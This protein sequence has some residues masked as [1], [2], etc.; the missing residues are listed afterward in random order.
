[1]KTPARSWSLLILA[2]LG[3]GG[4]DTDDVS[5]Q[6]GLPRAE[7]DRISR[8]VVRIVSLAGGEPIQSGSGT[9]V[10]SSGRIYT[11]RHVVEGGEDFLIE[12][13]EDPNEPPTP[14][15][16]ARLIGYSPDIDFAQLQIDRDLNGLAKDPATLDLPFLSRA[17]RDPARGDR[18]FVFGYPAIGDGYQVLT[19]G[20]LT[21]IRNG[22]LNDERLP[23]WYQTDAQISPGNSGGLAVNDRGE[24]LGIPT[25]V[26]SEERTLGRLGGILA[27]NAV[28][29][30][31]DG[32]LASDVAGMA[33]GTTSPVIENGRLD[34]GQEP[35]FGNATLA[36]GFSPDP[37]TVTLASG[38]E[39][40]VGYLGGG[41]TGHAAVAPDYRINWTGSGGALRV[42]FVGEDG[43]D[44][45]LLINRP[46]GSWVCNDDWS[47]GTVDPGIVLENAPSGQYDIWVGSYAAG[48][49]VGG[50]L[51]VTELE[52]EPTSVAS[53]GLDVS[54]DPYFGT[55]A[56]RA[57][58]DESV[59]ATEITAGGSVDVGYLGGGCIGFAGTAPDLRLNWTGGGPSL[60]IGFEAEDGGDATLIVNLP[61]GTWRCIDDDPAG[62]VDPFLS[63]PRPANGQY[64][65][66]VGTYQR[67]SFIPGILVLLEGDGGR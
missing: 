37:H 18:I 31:V 9:V 40:S 67:G 60:D 6:S 56:L 28:Q 61:D 24:F 8:S 43:G 53:S 22:T 20:T 35:F 19:E 33:S 38:G 39:V 23:V 55:I 48:A 54:G 11:N 41:C 32:G 14:R 26:R 27:Y 36:A 1:M 59:Y 45:T 44:T 16:L 25:A 66:W 15:F 57:G 17:A 29:A 3:C 62:G 13:L 42:F 10:T 50:T 2:L 65:I 5:A 64:D 63:L 49:F 58:T 51:H 46:D 34:F 52:L 30:A 47:A 21:T 12:F 4:L 7:I